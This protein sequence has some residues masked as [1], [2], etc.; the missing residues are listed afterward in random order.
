MNKIRKTLAILP[1]TAAL[2]GYGITS[3]SQVTAEDQK[4]IEAANCDEIVKEHRNF[5]A[6]EKELAEEIRRTSASTTASNVLGV[7]S[8]AVVGLGFF[9]WNDQVDAKTNLAELTAYREA[10]AAEGRKKNC[11]L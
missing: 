10:I 8:L 2:A 7:A 4:L 9:S 5:S 6:A 11:K 1:L 3:L